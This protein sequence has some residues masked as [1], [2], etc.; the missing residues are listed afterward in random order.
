MMSAKFQI[1]CLLLWMPTAAMAGKGSIRLLMDSNAG[2]ELRLEMTQFPLVQALNEI[3]DKT[4]IL[5]HYSALPDGVFNVTCVEP[6]VTRLLRCLLDKKADFVFRY[7]PSMPTALAKKMPEEI[8]VL[9]GNYDAVTT[10]GYGTAEPQAIEKKQVADSGPAKAQKAVQNDNDDEVNKLLAQAKAKDPT[11]RADAIAGLATQ[12]LEHDSAI[13][14]VLVDA[15]SDK[16]A[17]IREQAVSSLTRREGDKAAAQL[18]SALEDSDASV[19]LMVV[20]NAGENASLLQQALSDSD[21]TV[22]TLASMKLDEL[23]KIGNGK[24]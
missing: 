7:S 9:G 16:N 15:L 22:R 4:G 14:K 17:Q 11:I 2:T 20:D 23:S 13:H 1:I 24:N 5:I 19:R 21:E 8:W 3:A 18:Q 12:G 6:T 10:A